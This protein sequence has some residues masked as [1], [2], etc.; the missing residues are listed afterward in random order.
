MKPQSVVFKTSGA[1]KTSPAKS[2]SRAGSSEAE[3]KQGRRKLAAGAKAG[4]ARSL[5]ESK[6]CSG[7]VA[8]EPETQGW[9][10]HLEI[11]TSE[12]MAQLL[13]EV[14]SDLPGPS[15][16]EEKK[17]ELNAGYATHV[18]C[19]EKESM[20]NESRGDVHTAPPPLYPEVEHF[21]RSSN[22]DAV[23][24]LQKSVSERAAE[25]QKDLRLLTQTKSVML[26]RQAEEE[27]NREA[28]EDIQ[29][30][31]S[32]AQHQVKSATCNANTAVA[33]VQATCHAI[34][35]EVDTHLATLS[36]IRAAVVARKKE[37]EAAAEAYAS[38]LG[39]WAGDARRLWR[40]RLEQ[41]VASDALQVEQ[42]IRD[43]LSPPKLIV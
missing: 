37:H 33:E 16:N 30:F 15:I 21:S 12:V 2:M 6:F 17:P 24:C 18:G 26:C 5:V 32:A 25:L 10:S 34:A 7:P 38:A 22:L 35:D 42:H 3:E 41:R 27:L 40:E 29:K 43:M 23:V 13:Q 20:S 39:S 4:S 8:N 28:E 9:D 11:K 36:Q 14:V 1:S 31:E 19:Q